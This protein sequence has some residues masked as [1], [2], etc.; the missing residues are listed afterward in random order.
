MAKV[1]DLYYAALEADKAFS[2]A[3]SLEYGTDA[4]NRRYDTQSFP[5]HIQAL[6]RVKVATDDNYRNEV[7]GNR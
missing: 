4:C 1:H 7:K 6:F 2:E 3:L 5:A